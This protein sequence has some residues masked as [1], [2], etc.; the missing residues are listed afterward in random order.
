MEWSTRHTTHPVDRLYSN[1]RAHLHIL[2]ENLRTSFAALATRTY[3]T[4]TLLK[5]TGNISA[6]S[7]ADILSVHCLA[8]SKIQRAS[9][10]L[11]FDP[12]GYKLRA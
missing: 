1:N 8:D 3:I 11:T 10:T 4:V 7:A 5:P 9:A 2:D 6:Q 12:R